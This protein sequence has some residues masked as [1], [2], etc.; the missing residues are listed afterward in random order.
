[1]ART[2]QLP[3]SSVAPDAAV[4]GNFDI[5]GEMLLQAYK[6]KDGTWLF[7]IWVRLPEQAPDSEPW[8][9]FWRQPGVSELAE[10]RRKNGLNPHPPSFGSGA[11]P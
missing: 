1:L 10:L 3:A 11:K 8:Q 4:F 9:E 5:A 6:E 2:G 7:P